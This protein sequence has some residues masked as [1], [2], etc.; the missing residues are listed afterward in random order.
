MPG[1]R[2]QDVARLLG[3]P[4]G[5]VRRLSRDGLVGAPGPRRRI[6][7]SFRDLVL[8]RAAA[9]LVRAKVPAARVRRA[10]V[11][12]R[13]QLPGRSLA[14]VRVAA[15][16]RR[17]VVRHGGRAWL[18]DSGQ[19]AI[20]FEAAGG[21]RTVA[22]LARG[23]SGTPAAR[24]ADA[25]AWYEA[26]CALEATS[27]R[28]ARE[29]YRRALALDPGHAG[30]NVNCGRLLHEAGD[31]EGAE[32]CYR[33]ALADR[34]QAAIAAFDLGVV[35]EDQ[36]RDDAALLAYARALEA[37]PAHADAHYNAS[38]L[39]ER[40]GRRAEALRHLGAYRRLTRA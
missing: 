22:P 8:L 33:R 6:R 13:E 37:D 25:E 17:V 26:G 30:A 19:L 4:V 32:A 40:M 14:E 35:L 21:G 36:G 5:T 15:E 9:G 2:P 20:D 23:R 3:L 27:P 11:R 31:L 18:P 12:L 24:R 7:L 34:A 1:Y 16:G 29:A 28:E 10:L 39:L 38:R